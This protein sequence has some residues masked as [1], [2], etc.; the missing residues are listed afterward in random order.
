[1]AGTEVATAATVGT[2]T[3]ATVG[4][5]AVA[6]VIGIVI[7][8][9]TDVVTIDGIEIEAT[10]KAGSLEVNQTMRHER[11]RRYAENRLRESLL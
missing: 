8:I 11:V 4:T 7:V 1:M 3:A 5:A 6:S 9:A 2:V 10:V